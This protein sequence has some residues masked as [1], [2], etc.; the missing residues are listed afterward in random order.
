MVRH[1]PCR[2]RILLR[3][4]CHRSTQ[5]KIPRNTFLGG[6]RGTESQRSAKRVGTR[7]VRTVHSEPFGEEECCSLGV[8]V[9]DLLDPTTVLWFL[10]RSSLPLLVSSVYIPLL[11]SIVEMMGAMVRL[12]RSILVLCDAIGDKL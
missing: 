12:V 6:E 5:A 3:S 2:P 8:S 9:R 1:P 11:S 4:A 10:A 7:L